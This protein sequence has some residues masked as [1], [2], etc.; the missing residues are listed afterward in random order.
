MRRQGLMLA[1]S[2]AVLALIWTRLAALD[3]VAA[4]AALADLP[5]WRWGLA[6]VATAVS[7]AALGR[8]D[9]LIHRH[10]G[11]GVPAAQ[12]RRAGVAAIAF[13]QAAGLGVLTGVLARWRLLPGLGI[14]PALAVT[15]W[16]A[17]GF[18]SALVTLAAAAL[19]VGTV[20][21]D[22][23]V[24]PT[25]GVAAV[26][27]LLVLVLPGAL[28]VWPAL[29]RRLPTLP[30]LAGLWCYAA[31]D[32]GAACLA[33]WLLWP[34][35]PGLGALYP[36][37]LL[38]VT[39]GLLS[40]LPGGLG[41]FEVALLTLLAPSVPQD[42]MT[43]V[44]GYRVVT[45]VLP[46]LLALVP[47]A[48]P[49]LLRR[50]AVV[51]QPLPPDLV[52][53]TDLHG[54]SRAEA[55]VL[56]QSGGLV[57]V[58][59]QGALGL[60]TTG[61]TL[62]QFLDPLSGRQAA[63]LDDLRVVARAGGRVALAYR[64]GPRAAVSARARGWRLRHIADEALL[65]P[66]IF[67]LNGPAHSTLRRK[68][69]HAALAGVTVATPDERPAALPWDAMATVDAA[70]QRARGPARGVTMGRFGAAT[71]AQ[72]VYLAWADGQL[73]AF[74]SFHAGRSERTLDLMRIRPEAPDGTMQALIMAALTDAR[75]DGIARLS[76]ATI[77][78]R[79]GPQATG[80]QHGLA[81][82][83]LRLAGA[84]G[85]A[86]FKDGF[87]PRYEPRY[88]AAPSWLALGLGLLDLAA[89]IRRPTGSTDT[90]RQGPE[91]AVGDPRDDL[92]GDHPDHPGDRY[93]PIAADAGH[94]RAQDGH[95]DYAVA[96]PA[97]A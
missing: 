45:H 1:L 50:G 24:G 78:A 66:V 91:P 49:G 20:P 96:K 73:V 37:F 92:T 25:R 76:L 32:T 35:A 87:A 4:L 23:P 22:W 70:W 74:A 33:L 9:A 16:V 86:Q 58:R 34:D 82:W 83:H 27:L 38:A 39:A 44:L 54:A 61:Q 26:V 11:T 30:T 47:L 95:E 19:L 55:A 31:V 42:M 69:R 65:N 57:L 18:L 41:A 3:P 77:P 29:A 64:L 67:S 59:P 72:Q 94:G 52:C 7:F 71:R 84:S 51:A 88:A 40:G 56:L 68:L 60:I 15:L 13:S 89:A 17:A 10:L 79:A 8:Y 81:W 46:G 43:A 93:N 36:A 63:L 90:G 5:V 97:A 53:P 14:G 85:L 48:R 62:V 28:L 6:A 75:R 21:P 12:A 80:W 2:A